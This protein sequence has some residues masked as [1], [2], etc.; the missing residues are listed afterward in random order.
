MA[1]ADS[2]SPICRLLIGVGGMSVALVAASTEW[3]IGPLRVLGIV[4]LLILALMVAGTGR[5]HI[6]ERDADGALRE[7]VKIEKGV[8]ALS[9]PALEKGQQLKKQRSEALAQLDATIASYA[10]PPPVYVDAARDLSSTLAGPDT[11]ARQQ[12]RA[13]FDRIFPPTAPTNL[14]GKLEK[15]L[16]AATKAVAAAEATAVTADD[17]LDAATAACVTAREVVPDS[18]GP[19]C[20]GEPT[21][22]E[23][24]LQMAAVRLKLA[25]YRAAILSRSD[26][27]AAVKALQKLFDD[28][29]GTTAASTEEPL[30]I[31][32]A[33]EAGGNA[34]FDDL[35]PADDPPLALGWL[36][37]LLLAGAV[38]ISW[39]GLERL[40]ARQQPGPVT[41]RFNK[42]GA[43][44]TAS[45]NITD[46]EATFRAALLT[47]LTEPAATPGATRSSP[48]T[49]L[50]EMAASG[51]AWLQVLVKTL[52]SVLN[53]PH[54][55][56]VVADVAAPETKG[57]K[58]QLM[59][60]VMDMSDGRQVAVDTFNDKDMSTTCRAAGFWAAA[61]ILQRST[62]VPSWASWSS[63]TAQA[64]AAYESDDESTQTLVKAVAQAPSSGLLL[65][66]LADSY[67]VAGQHSQALGLYARAVAAHP[68][69]FVA[70]YRMAASLALL[71]F[72]PDKHWLAQ[73]TSERLR[74]AAEVQRAC[75]QLGLKEEEPASL[76]DPAGGKAEMRE[77]AISLYSR[78][79]DDLSAPASAI[80]LFRRSQ[81]A[82]LGRSLRQLTDPYGETRRALWMTKSARL[83]ASLPS[84]GAISDKDASML[85]AVEKRATDR[86]SWWQLSY[87]IACFY[88]RQNETEGVDLAMTWLETAQSRPGSGQMA[89]PWLTT[90]PD[91]ASLKTQA[92][93]RTLITNLNTP[94]KAN[95]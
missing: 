80:R 63:Q 7:L 94:V 54:G 89:G 68:L 35:L 27:A 81:R 44:T 9:K 39:R 90:D 92:R 70:R 36:A 20:K 13:A 11:V 53:D 93:F 1:A 50:A 51:T 75:R 58:W 8:D 85:A 31:V 21:G 64:L 48:I 47:N 38:L 28:A 6:A 41:L 25:Q 40:S 61:T 88:A 34:L 32:H 19:M 72:E 77:L 2:P 42:S 49:D 14:D 76:A 66:K 18:P 91:L 30:T 22:E 17:V 55:Y 29:R 73:P 82:S 83:V 59:V 3:T 12:A 71:S 10:A 5:K 45:D 24:T 84:T 4:G 46:Q 37:W 33:V 87:N 62:R 74:V 69:Y 65:Q 78:L 26:D 43:V 95:S 79:I 67:D 86:R 15:D 52:K 60:R 56:E 23:L 57:G 16:D